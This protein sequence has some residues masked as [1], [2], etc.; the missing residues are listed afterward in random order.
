MSNINRS[1]YHLLKNLL[2][3]FCQSIYH[4]TKHF[5]EY[6][7]N[8][9]ISNDYEMVSFD[10]KLLFKRILLGNTIERTL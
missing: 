8:E 9:E 7:E 3:L 6:I 1:R 2:L 5:I 4:I 10:V